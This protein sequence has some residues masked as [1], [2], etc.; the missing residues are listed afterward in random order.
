MIYLQRIERH[1]HW[2][3]LLQACPNWRD[4]HE[5]SNSYAE[6]IRHK[7]MMRCNS[8][9]ARK[10]RLVIGRFSRPLIGWADG[11]NRWSLPRAQVV[12]SSPQPRWNAMAKMWE[13]DGIHRSQENYKM[14]KQ[15]NKNAK[16]LKIQDTKY[17]TLVK[18]HEKQ[19]QRKREQKAYY[20]P[21]GGSRTR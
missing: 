2:F 10:R 5:T 17:R 6:E 19:C 7:V 14:Q 4:H 20:H 8:K 13:P 9:L 3:C 21:G 18:I 16:I 12:D 1:M 11:W 15:P